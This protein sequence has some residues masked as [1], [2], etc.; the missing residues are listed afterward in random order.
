MGMARG[1]M[2][3]ETTC[4]QFWLLETAALDEECANLIE[5]KEKKTIHPIL[6]EEKQFSRTFIPC[7]HIR[8]SCLCSM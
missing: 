5:N 6:R 7:V 1:K 8:D 2:S 3:V 4:K